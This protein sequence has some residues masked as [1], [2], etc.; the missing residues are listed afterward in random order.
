M[1][2]T[3]PCS[4]LLTSIVLFLKFA[5]FNICINYRNRSRLFNRLP[6]PDVLDCDEFSI[7]LALCNAENTLF[8]PE[9]EV[10]GLDV[11]ELAFSSSKIFFTSSE[12]SPRQDDNFVRDER[13]ISK[14]IWADNC[15]LF[16]KMARK[17]RAVKG[18]WEFYEDWGRVFRSTAVQWIFELK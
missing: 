13:S 10:S 12:A 2:I 8:P 6:R 16:F 5:F 15:S 11:S 17:W 9:L 18:Q 1:N 3:I 14:N 4:M 7:D